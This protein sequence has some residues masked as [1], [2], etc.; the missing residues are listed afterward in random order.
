MDTAQEIDLAQ[1]RNID[2]HT[3]DRESLA[4]IRDVRIDW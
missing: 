2:I 1:M 3:V 4:D